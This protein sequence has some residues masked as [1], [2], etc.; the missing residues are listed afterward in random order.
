M[1]QY[2]IEIRVNARREAEMEPFLPDEVHPALQDPQERLLKRAEKMMA[3]ASFS[4]PSPSSS[5]L[6]FE[7]TISLRA[8]SFAELAEIIG[9]FD[10]LAQHLE[11]DSQARS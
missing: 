8:E 6:G 7:K 10:G 11:M 3:G 2:T 4:L 9:K 5:S 1:A